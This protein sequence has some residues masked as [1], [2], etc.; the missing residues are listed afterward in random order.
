MQ[1]YQYRFCQTLYK[2]QNLL[3]MRN[4]CLA[5]LAST[6]SFTACQKTSEQK[7]VAGETIVTVKAIDALCSSVIFEIQEDSLKKYGEQNF[8]YKG[9]KYDGVFSS[10]LLCAEFANTNLNPNNDGRSEPSS[11]KVLISKNPPTSNCENA[12]C[13]AV[14]TNMPET[15][16]FIHPIR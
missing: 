6:L 9:K 16:Y 14:L 12:T 15:F 11:F 4:L 13:M 3:N 7:Q 2:N 8:T 10:Q 5:L 1:R